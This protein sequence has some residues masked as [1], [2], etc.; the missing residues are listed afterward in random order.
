MKLVSGEI[1]GELDHVGLHCA[2]NTSGQLSKRG[3]CSSSLKHVKISVRG[4]P[5]IE[6]ARR[7]GFHGLNININWK[8]ASCAGSGKRFDLLGR[9]TQRE[10]AARIRAG[11]GRNRAPI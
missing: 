2:W 9:P 10:A 5:E 11:T 1:C 6:I 7:R 4:V 8:R 3:G